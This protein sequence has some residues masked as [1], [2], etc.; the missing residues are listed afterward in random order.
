MTR[1]CYDV[2][3]RTADG[4]DAAEEILSLGSLIAE[5]H[6]KDRPGGPNVNLGLGDV[7]FDG[8]FDFAVCQGAAYFGDDS[9]RKLGSC[10]DS[11]YWVCQRTYGSRARLM[12][13]LF[14]GLGSIGKDIAKPFIFTGYYD[15]EFRHFVRQN[16]RH[17]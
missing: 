15:S 13:I 11:K 14:A 8:V 17:C 10:G 5:I 7:D 2:G 6:I 1:I 9:W 4:A 12:K 16:P 3:N